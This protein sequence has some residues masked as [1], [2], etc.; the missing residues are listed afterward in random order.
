MKIN[1]VAKQFQI[2][3]LTLLMVENYV[4]IV[5]QL[6]KRI[7]RGFLFRCGRANQEGIHWHERVL[8]QA[9]CHQD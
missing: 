6:M 5:R 2:T 9:I 8:E 4:M 1:I 7:G 3:L